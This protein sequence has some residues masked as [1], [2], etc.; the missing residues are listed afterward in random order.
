[1]PALAIQNFGV[2]RNRIGQFRIDKDG[3]LHA[4]RPPAFGGRP[5]PLTL[6]PNGKYAYHSQ[7]HGFIF[8]YRVAPGGQLVFEHDIGDIAASGTGRY[9][10]ALRFDRLCRYAYVSYLDD[11]DDAHRRGVSH[12]VV[13]RIARH[14]H[15][16]RVRLSNNDH[17]IKRD[18]KIVWEH[19]LN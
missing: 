19:A 14:G 4:L 12:D 18:G 3:H 9:P 10:S 17:F 11:F 1:M 8:Q 16:Q 6:H 7:G 5:G 13:F 15:L 2:G